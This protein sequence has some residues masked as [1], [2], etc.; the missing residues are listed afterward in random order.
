MIN[1]NLNRDLN[2]ATLV[3]GECSHHCATLA[4]LISREESQLL[5][6]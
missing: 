1:L 6:T 2:L 5:E 4:P 3:G